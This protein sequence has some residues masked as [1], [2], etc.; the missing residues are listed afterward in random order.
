[1][2]GYG[3]H[4][5]G[6]DLKIYTP[7]MPPEVYRVIYDQVHAA[8][9]SRFLV[10]ASPIE[11]PAKRDYGD[12][13]VFVCWDNTGCF[14]KCRDLPEIRK[15]L[16]GAELDKIKSLVGATHTLVERKHNSTVQ[17]A[18]P[19]PH[20]V[21]S[22]HH[23]DL[24]PPLAQIDLHIYRSMNELEWELF[25]CVHGDLFWFFHTM[26]RPFGLT[27]GADGLQLR[28]SELEDQTKDHSILL[29][30]EPAQILAFL[31][32]QSAEEV[33]ERTFQSCD[34][35]FEYASRC[36]FFHDF[37]DNNI[38]DADRKRMKCKRNYELFICLYIGLNELDA[39][40]AQPARYLGY[41]LKTS[42][43]DV[44]N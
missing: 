37:D 16:V 4:R 24:G 39:N 35:L 28:I 29:S 9:R 12:L 1:M 7:R 25:K 8:L 31:G 43:L 14:D 17:L 23:P 21:K 20:N 6:N 5:K 40:G 32:F 27:L 10:V 19:W 44:E 3:F 13:D 22:H 41:G 30:K 18:V 36:R 42:C 33:W 38:S 26:I 15:T 11:T 2:G 34:E